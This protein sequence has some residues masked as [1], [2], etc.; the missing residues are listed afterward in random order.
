M[1]RQIFNMIPQVLIL[2]K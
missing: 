2:F 1:Y